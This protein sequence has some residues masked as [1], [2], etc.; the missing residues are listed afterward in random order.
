KIQQDRVFKRASRAVFG[1]DYVNQEDHALHVGSVDPD[2]LNKTIRGGQDIQLGKK[3]F[4]EQEEG[5]KMAAQE[6]ENVRKQLFRAQ[7]KKEMR[8]MGEIEQEN[9]TAASLPGAL[10]DAMERGNHYRSEGEADRIADEF[11]R[12]VEDGEELYCDQEDMIDV[13]DQDPESVAATAPNSLFA[14]NYLAGYATDDREVLVEVLARA[15]VELPPEGE[16]YLRKSMGD[17]SAAVEDYTPAADGVLGEEDDVGGPLSGAGLR[18]SISGQHNRASRRSQS[19]SPMR[20]SSS[21][22]NRRS[23]RR[24]SYSPNRR[25]KVDSY[26]QTSRGELRRIQD[27]LLDIDDRLLAMGDG[28][29]THRAHVQMFD[30]SLPR[31]FTS[32]PTPTAR[33]SSRTKARKKLSLGP[34]LVVVE[35]TDTNKVFD[36]M[37]EDEGGE[38]DQ[39]SPILGGAGGGRQS[40]IMN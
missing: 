20:R 21:M 35:E 22:T 37:N 40:F 11:D 32:A 17:K 15:G 29:A 30:S 38:G 19:S 31:F 10:F 16:R 6:F 33:T 28:G 13:L 34:G 5:A 9:Q 2:A 3:V 12:G 24:S 36:G 27:E 14:D 8:T 25:S 4:V 23:T 26:Q 7:V 18:T 1:D 39:R